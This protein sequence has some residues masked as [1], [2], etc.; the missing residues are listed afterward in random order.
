MRCQR[1]YQY[2][3]GP[4]YSWRLGFSLGIDPISQPGKKCN[5]NCCYCQLGET[6]DFTNERC[7]FVPS[8]LIMDEV[9]AL[10]KMQI[11]CIT[12]SGRGE[13]TLAENLGDLI[14]KV[15][16]LRREKIAVITNA[17]LIH[18]LDVQQDVALADIV[19][20]KLDA[21]SQKNFNKINKPCQSMDF[22]ILVEALCSFRKRFKGSLA[23]QV[24]FL[25]E[26]KK[27]AVRIAQLAHKIA[28]DVVHLHT[29]LRLSSAS[30]LTMKEL[31]EIKKAFSGL[32]VASVYDV[33]VQKAI[34][35]DPEQTASR[36]GE[37]ETR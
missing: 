36:H 31:K 23:L 13:P 33:P 37:G 12:F 16:K 20:V 28:P 5:F 7:L 10:P 18:R 26:N 25:Q 11:D 27:E 15:R 21:G 22:K 19:S 1:Q 34:P 9:K 17:A 2:V 29:P 3:Y 35:L 32:A 30:P 6:K 8:T 4:V 14:R 24:M